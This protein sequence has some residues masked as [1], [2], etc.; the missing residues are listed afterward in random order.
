MQKGSVLVFGSINVDLIAHADP[1]RQ[2]D[3]YVVGTGFTTNSGGKGLNTAMGCAAFNSSRVHML[4]RVGLDIY[5]QFII[6]VIEQA[7]LSAKYVIRDSKAHTGIGHLR[8]AP[9]GEYDTVVVQGA[10]DNLCGEDFDSY[11]AENSAP[12][13]VITNLETPLAAIRHIAERSQDTSL[14]INVSPMVEGAKDAIALANLAVLNLSEA[15]TLM[16][17]DRD[18][19]PRELLQ[20]LREVTNAVIVMTLGERG[21]IAI[22]SKDEIFEVEGLPVKAINTVGAGDSFFAA[23]IM[24]LSLGASLPQA[25]EAGNQAGRFACL[26]SESHLSLSDAEAIRVSTGLNF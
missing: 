22:D 5:G 1:A 15:K 11:L 4:G 19:Q 17:I 25:L 21:A 24:A 18:L 23:L 26:R 14:A 6:G 13:F 20:Q 12:A 3:N 8:V 10:N 7:G 9:D 2:K 16:G